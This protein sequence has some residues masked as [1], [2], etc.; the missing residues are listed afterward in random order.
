MGEETVL[1]GWGLRL[2]IRKLQAPALPINS[3]HCIYEIGLHGINSHA[4]MRMAWQLINN[5]IIQQQQ[6]AATAKDMMVV[7]RSLPRA[8][9]SQ[10]WVSWWRHHDHVSTSSL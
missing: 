6:H 10:G 2:T 8:T 3:S 1:E 7:D 5:P 9:L 4:C